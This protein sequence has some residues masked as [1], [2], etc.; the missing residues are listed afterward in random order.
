MTFPPDRSR[1]LRALLVLCAVKIALLIVAFDPSGLIAFDLP[2]SLASR[3]VEWPIA[4]V[5]GI[6]V[7]GQ[8]RR[9]LPRSHLHV[10]VIGL[11][12][13]WL[14]AAWFA[15][16]RYLALFGED[17]RYLG[18]TY[19]ADM[20]ILYV[21]CAVAVRD[22]HDVAFLFTAIAIG[23]A[24]ALGYA[25][26]QAI[27]ADP[28][29]WQDTPAQRPFSTFGNPDHFGHFLSVL[30]G[31]SFGAAVVA[32]GLLATAISALVVGLSLVAAAV[33][34]TRG[35]ALGILASVVA[36]PIPITGRRRAAL[37]IALAS[38]AFVAIFTAT[39]LG[40]RVRATLSGAAIE[41]RTTIWAASV[42]AFAARPVAGYGPD[43]F[44][45]AYAEHRPSP[46]Q[47]PLAAMPQ[48]S[49]HNWLLDA[50]VMTGALGLAALVM[51]VA[52]GT[53]ALIALARSTPS[54]GAPLLLGWCAYWAHALV[55]VGSIAIGWVPWV[56]IGIA[57]G[58]GSHEPAR[59]I[60]SVPPWVSAVAMIVALVVA[61][62]GARVLLANRDALVM[63]HANA[64]GDVQ[65]ALDAAES[66]VTRD[67]AR[68]ENWNRLGIALDG[69][70]LWR[71]SLDAYREAAA[72]RPY[73]PIYW[74]NI[75][76][77]YARLALAGDA[78]SREEAVSAARRAVDADPRSSVGH[79]VLAEIAAAFGMCD[80]ARSEAAIT[81]TLQGP[82]LRARACG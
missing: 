51:L 39:P 77:T 25:G 63:E 82:D 27:G 21:A 52:L 1:W 40:E 60:R 15:Q 12:A 53:R 13:A 22:G 5:L 65:G 73:E 44:R 70:E 57:V 29:W 58:L 19:L 32:R 23:A 42:R 62:T 48:S 10:A 64:V 54:T 61:A 37:A 49:A 35:T 36:A 8:G 68:A 67:G 9:V 33:V 3:A 80:L 4:V 28:F 18:L 72:R 41:D 69:L 26:A 20:I 14:I 81:V 43:N 30:F 74:A 66:A 2:K 6:L 24:V 71:A 45:I 76:R 11:A 31:L 17:D 75:A 46:A 47:V 38:V 55:A 50:A 78:S 79:A 56:A 7:I 34:A 59:R 16:D